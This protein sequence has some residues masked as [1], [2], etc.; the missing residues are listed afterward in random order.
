[1]QV[2]IRLGDGG[3]G[4]DLLRWLR[5]D[6]IAAR[7]ELGVLPAEAGQSEMGTAD[8]VQVA[9][10]NVSGLGG[11]VVAVA[12]WR[13][14]RRQGQ[15]RTAAPTV[16]IQYETVT[17]EVTDDDPA[18]VRRIIDALTASGHVAATEDASGS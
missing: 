18:T 12:A 7:A 2:Q 6:P 14:A 8:V 10:D 17:V 9:L 15:A 13:D 16:R 1:M 4:R 3:D 5:N 11:L